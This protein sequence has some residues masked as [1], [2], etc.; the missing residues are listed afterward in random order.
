MIPGCQ[1]T[2]GESPKSRLKIYWLLKGL[3]QASC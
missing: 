2:L 1:L 3:K